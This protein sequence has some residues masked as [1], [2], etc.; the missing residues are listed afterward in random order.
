MASF[1]R[2]CSMDVFGE[3]F[4]DWAGQTTP[5]ETTMGLFA[6]VLCE[7]CGYVQ[8]DHDGNCITHSKRPGHGHTGQEVAK[9]AVTKP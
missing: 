5:E 7:D 1:C 2:Q 4:G 3:D 6:W 9:R 8:V